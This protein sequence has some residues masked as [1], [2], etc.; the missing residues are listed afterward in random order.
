MVSGLSPARARKTG[1]MGIFSRRKGRDD[2]GGL[3]ST[4]SVGAFWAWWTAEG[5]ALADASI[6][7]GPNDALVAAMSRRVSAVHPGL[8]WELSPGRDAEHCLVVSPE[9]DP[10]LR[11]AARRWVKGAPAADTTWEFADSRQSNRDPESMTLEVG[12]QTISFADV[13][14]GARREGARFDVSVH[15]PAFASLDERARITITFL[16]L[17][18]A[19]GETGV[20]LW[21]GE[22]TPSVVPP[23]DGF[24]L[25]GLRAV[26]RDL[27]AEFTDDDGQPQ[28]VILHGDGAS[29]PLVAMAQVP[30][31]PATAP[32]LDTHAGVAVPYADQTESGLPG[33]EALTELRA[34]EDSIGEVLGDRGRVVAHQSHAGVRLL[35]VYIDSTADDAVPSLTAVCDPWPQDVR[36]TVAPDPG[37]ANVVHLRT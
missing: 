32:D 31:H 8:A 30:L 21:V 13:V 22:V 11:G 37:W 17:D 12:G 16:S 33:H 2:R 28:W 27:E 29:G 20:E 34:L 6:A 5:R 1:P 10:A 7:G 15:H 23:L 3:G 24:G 18:T 25:T 19:L 26:V 14:V 36:I 35:H 9:G 4:E